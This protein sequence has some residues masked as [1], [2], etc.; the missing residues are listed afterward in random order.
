[1]ATSCAPLVRRLAIVLATTFTALAAPHAANAGSYGWPIRP[2][3]QQHPVRGFFGDPRIGEGADGTPSRKRS[4]SASTSRRRRNSSLRDRVRSD[5]LE[6]QRPE[7]VAI[8]SDDGW[9]SRTG[10]F[11]PSATDTPPWRTERSRAHRVRLGHVHFAELVDGEYVNPLASRRADAVSGRN[12]SDD[13]RVQLRARRSSRRED[14]ERALRPGRRD[15]GRDARPRAGKVGDK[16][17]MPAVV[18]WRVHGERSAGPLARRSTSPARSR[19]RAG[20]TPSTRPGRVRT[21]PGVTVATGA[22]PRGWNSDALEGGPH[23]LEVEADTR[24]TRRAARFASRS[25]TDD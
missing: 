1:M 3:D 7:T 25:R 21:I 9:S 22:G 4:T 23:V 15:L 13:P 8:R 24:G 19:T 6:P 16:P 14:I 20:S 11:P 17:V 12:A 10:T 2:F 5:R 18:R